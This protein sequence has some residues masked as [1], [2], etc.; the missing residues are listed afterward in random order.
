MKMRLLF[1]SILLI[2]SPHLAAG[3]FDQLIQEGVNAVGKGIQKAAGGKAVGGNTYNSDESTCLTD[4]RGECLKCGPKF[5][6]EDGIPFMSRTCKSWVHMKLW[7]Q[8]RSSLARVDFLEAVLLGEKEAK[9]FPNDSRAVTNLEGNPREY[10]Y[11]CRTTYTDSAGMKHVAMGVTEVTGTFGG[12][13]GHYRYSD[14]YMPWGNLPGPSSLNSDL[15]N[16]EHILKIAKRACEGIR[17]DFLEHEAP[18][19]EATAFEKAKERKAQIAW[20][21]SPEYELSKHYE[22]YFQVRA[23]NDLN[24]DYISDSQLK[25]TKKAI[26]AIDNKFKK[27]GVDTD[28]AYKEAEENPSEQ[29][30]KFLGGVK[31]IKFLG[32]ENNYNQQMKTS[33]SMLS[34]ALIMQSEQ[35]K[36]KEA[37]G[38]K[39]F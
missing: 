11:T 14:R 9:K 6:S 15:S 22:T 5:E 10:G 18:I 36:A 19:I 20:E 21:S 2:S 30:R 17:Q 27:Q 1:L 24:T 13:E 38:K 8:N 37:K 29:T 7:G 34:N 3:M 12:V 35:H 26:R 31:T 16:N 25:K 23:C 39:D 32:A 33:C 28:K 4:R